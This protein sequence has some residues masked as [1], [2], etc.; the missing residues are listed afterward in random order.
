[1]NANP[2][3]ENIPDLSLLKTARNFGDTS[4]RE[5]LRQAELLKLSL[6]IH[7]TFVYLKK[8]SGASTTSV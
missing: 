3:L 5:R 2:H 6:S 1:M 8:E 7:I 4:N